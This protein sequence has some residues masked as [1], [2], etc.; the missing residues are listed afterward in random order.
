VHLFYHDSQLHEFFFK[1]KTIYTSSFVLI[2]D[3]HINEYEYD[4]EGLR[5]FILAFDHFLV[6]CDAKD[7][8]LIAVLLVA[9]FFCVL[10]Y[11]ELQCAM[12]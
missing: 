4:G 10:I 12:F 8:E 9:A 1:K 11:F 2:P 5:Y 6:W 3:F 7:R